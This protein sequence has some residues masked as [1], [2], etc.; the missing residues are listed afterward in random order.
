MAQIIVWR[1]V[2]GN[3]SGQCS[4][5]GLGLPFADLGRVFGIGSEF[6]RQLVGIAYIQRLTVTMID[7]G[8]LMSRLFELLFNLIL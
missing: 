8:R 2:A 4:A 6:Q 3:P 5:R 1:P 7:E